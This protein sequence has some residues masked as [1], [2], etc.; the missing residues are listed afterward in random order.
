VTFGQDGYLYGTTASGGDCR[1]CYNGVVFNLGPPPPICKTSAATCFWTEN[2]LHTFAGPPVDGQDPGWGD[3]VWDTAGNIYGTT[4]EGGTAGN[5]TV[6][7]L[8]VRNKSYSVIYN[9]LGYP[10]GDTPQNGVVVDNIG[11]VF[12]TSSG[13]G[14]NNS[15]SVFKL[16]YIPGVGWTETILHSFQGCDEFPWA[17]LT[18]DSSGNLYGATVVGCAGGG[19][20]FELSPSGDTWTYKVIYSIP[21][22]S[23]QAGPH[24]SLTMDAAGNL[25]GTTEA[26]GKYH[27]GN[28]FKLSNT[29]DGWVYSSLYDFIGGTDGAG[30]LSPVTIDTDGTLY[31]TTNDGGVGPCASGC[32]VV[33]MIKP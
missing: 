3:L 8:N 32:G 1:Y 20:V 26:A 25:Y 23:G 21:G 9:F 24:A 18:M 6:F 27:M 31:G 29:P 19:T 11:N 13:G 30:P 2:V 12:G 33:W 15:G 10:D 7:E 17:G 22:G 28:V 4:R 5:G 14:P 16:T